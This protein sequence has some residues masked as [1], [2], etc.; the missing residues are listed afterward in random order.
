MLDLHM[1]L[2]TSMEVIETFPEKYDLLD[3]KT[4]IVREEMPRG[5]NRNVVSALEWNKSWGVFDQN[6]RHTILTGSNVVNL[7]IS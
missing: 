7:I 3:V 1:K 6:I 4:D 5:L 2:D